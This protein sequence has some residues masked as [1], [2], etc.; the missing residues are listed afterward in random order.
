MQVT[1]LAIIAPGLKHLSIA[2]AQAAPDD[3]GP[4]I[5]L[6]DDAVRV[7]GAARLKVSALEEFVVTNELRRRAAEDIPDKRPCLLVSVGAGWP[8]G[9]Q[10]RA[11]IAIQPLTDSER[12]RGLEVDLRRADRTGDLR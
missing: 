9:D 12:H 10:R 3:G 5:G 6:A 11:E 7:N 8:P 1:D 4:Q 2:E